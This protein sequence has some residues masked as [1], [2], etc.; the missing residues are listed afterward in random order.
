[1]TSIKMFELNAL[2]VNFEEQTDIV[3]SI[4]NEKDQELQFYKE[5]VTTLI[6]INKSLQTQLNEEKAKQNDVKHVRS[7]WEW[8]A[9]F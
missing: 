5:Q 1:M 9:T 6:E 3:T 2:D 8:F 7:R 4:I